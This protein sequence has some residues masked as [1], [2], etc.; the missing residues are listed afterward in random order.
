M[1]KKLL[2]IATLAFATLTN[3]N[4]FAQ[5]PSFSWVK[6]IGGPSYE[7]PTAM[8]LDATGNI[9]T[10]G[11]FN[12]TTDFDPSASV[13]TLTAF[14][15][16]DIFVSKLTV[17]GNFVWAKQFGGTAYDY[18]NSIAVDASGNVYTTGWFDGPADFDPGAG[19]ATLTPAGGPS[20]GLTDVFIS[21]LDA[22]GNFVWVKQIGG[23]GVDKGNGIAVDASGNIFTTGAYS[24][25]VD[26]DPNAPVSN[27]PSSGGTDNFISKLDAS[28]NFV[29]AKKTGGSNYDESKA[30]VLDA[31]GNIYTTGEYGGTVDFDPNA[32]VSNLTSLASLDIFVSK[33]DASGNF[34]WAKSIGG[35]YGS[36]FAAAIAL[37]A[38]GN[39]F[40]TGEF[41]ATPSFPFTAGTTTLISFNSSS[42]DT[43]ISKLDVAGNYLW[44]KG[45]GGIND[46]KPFAISAD[47]SG[48]VYNIG[49]FGG[50]VDFN[51]GPGVNTLTTTL[52]SANDA[53]I[54]KLDGTGNY[55]WATQLGGSGD[56]YGTCIALNS[57]GEIFTAGR[58]LGTVDFDPGAATTTLTAVGSWDTYIHKLGSLSS[59]ISESYSE[60]NILSLFP[61]PTTDVLNVFLGSAVADD[62]LKL[63]ILNT[64]GQLVLTET[65]S[66]KHL[67][68]NTKEL[69]SGLYI[70]K[71]YNNNTILSSQ[72][73]IKQ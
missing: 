58:F 29:W 62:T 10:V 50:T 20:F 25:T 18:G 19:A 37:D 12:G 70:V 42:S 7:S 23:N 63:E 31:S 41:K 64:F 68:L 52:G 5:V 40:T 44:T 32:G 35:T 21:K 48:N 59:G 14:G 51:P 4:T 33:L 36:Q 49:Y 38:T 34:V 66:G 69:S 2:S 11:R 46:E 6:Q 1:M 47:V 22:S 9:Y 3:I 54:L 43:Y 16:D 71:I 61:N 15:G 72:K 8:V 28:G 65:M 55:V 57:A 13:F 73:I 53:Y 26:F 39:V 24:G 30:I 67:E 27:L 56:D 17:S 45:F 60:N